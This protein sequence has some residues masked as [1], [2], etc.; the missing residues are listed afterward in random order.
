MN[1]E[2]SQR[3]NHGRAPGFDSVHRS[4]FIV[5][6]SSALAIVAAY[7]LLAVIVVPVFPH[8]VSPN[9]LTR[10]VLAAAIVED[11]TIEVSR[12]AARLGPRFEDL[13]ER[14]G[15]LYSN[16]APGLALVSLPG[17]VAGRAVS[18]SVRTGV[19][20][21][22]LVGATLPLVLMAL[23]F[24]VLG[25]ETDVDGS[26]IAAVIFILLFATPLFT[27]GLLLF[28]HALIAAC[29]FGAWALLFIR[30]THSVAAGALMG[31]AVASEYPAA[32][33][34][35]VVM[36]ALVVTRA[37]QTLGRVIA[38][39]VPFAIIL[40]IY[41]HFAFGSAFR[42]SPL[43]DRLPEYRELGRS[44][45][46]GLQLPSPMNAVRLLLDPGRGLLVF[47]PVLILGIPALLAARRR[48]SRSAFATLI[49]IPASLF[50]LYSSY[51][52][53]HGGWAVGPR[54]I[55]ACIPFLVYALL[56]RDGSPAES[57]LT[58]WSVAAVVITSLVFPFVPNGFPF[59]WTTLS[60][61]LLTDGLIAPNAFH[62]VA[63]PLALVIPFA[64]LLAAAR[65]NVLLVVA[66]AA[67]AVVIGLA[68]FRLA[69]PPLLRLQRA[70]IADVYF[71]RR[72]TLDRAQPVPR[73]LLRRRDL[74]RTLPPESWPF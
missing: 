19:T 60:L 48:M 67:I 34:V 30:R 70:Y 68:G 62:L 7:A 14:D 1:D 27:Y 3:P 52:N 15:K 9:E 57:L 5:H 64:I 65:R 41:Q 6:R 49:A 72:G 47:S 29:L 18:D 13:A 55:V 69:P 32:V 28:S 21:M 63:R 43:Y 56:Y 45:M 10:W 54:Y 37:W 24:V 53:W 8:F 36:V 73:A 51:P 17:Y 58:G 61:P 50:V 31:V 39:G 4:S 23:L 46:F 12:P 74:E 16:K 59:P 66:G 26:R 2:Q 40:G 71:E 33:A 25:R 11:R 42:L 22:R 35:A 38:G 44:G 20:A